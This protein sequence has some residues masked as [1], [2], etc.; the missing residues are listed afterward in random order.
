[1]KW[2]KNI[3]NLAQ[4]KSSLDG[5]SDSGYITENIFILYSYWKI[6]IIIIIFPYD[7]LQ[8]AISKYAFQSLAS[9][10]LG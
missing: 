5:F 1:M 4:V 6:W 7:K 10:V 2:N 3:F 9:F 8:Y